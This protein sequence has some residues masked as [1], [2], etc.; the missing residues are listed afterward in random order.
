MFV[1]EILNFFAYFE[2]WSNCNNVFDTL[3]PIGYYMY[4][5]V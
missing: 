3:K 2:V 1:H 5:Q 4:H